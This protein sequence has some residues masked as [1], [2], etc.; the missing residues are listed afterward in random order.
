MILHVTEARHLG[1]FRVELSFDDGRSGVADLTGQLDGPVFRELND[2]EKFASFSLDPELK[3]I[4]WS[5]GADLAPEFLYFLAFKDDP[6]LRELFRKWGYLDR[7]PAS[8]QK[9]AEDP[10]DYGERKDG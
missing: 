6:D 10:A 3:T 9:V 5:N 2:P 4:A 7:A 8:P 1:G